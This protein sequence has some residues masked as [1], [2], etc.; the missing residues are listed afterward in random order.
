MNEEFDT[1]PPDSAD[2][3]E[4]RAAGFPDSAPLLPLTDVS[5]FD[6]PH[7]RHKRVLVVAVIVVILGGI[8]LTDL[9]HHASRASEAASDIAVVKE[10]NLDIKPCAFALREALAVNQAR[11]DRS[12]SAADARAV[13][14]LLR[15][16]QNAC[17]FTDQSIFDLS[18]IEVPGSASGKILNQMISTVTTWSTSDALAVIEDIQA[19][20]TNPNDT[21]SS[22]RLTH[23]ELVLAADL[24]AAEAQLAA[25]GRLVS[26]TLPALGLTAVQ[27][28]PNA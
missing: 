12:M 8:V 22:D 26:T 13:P 17:S 4:S 16:D 7:K 23:Y 25:A 18:S 20:W 28:Q 9:P 2:A 5:V 11:L 1:A 19:L 15:D 14:G 6:P 21:V 24:A 27:T 10:V 3:P